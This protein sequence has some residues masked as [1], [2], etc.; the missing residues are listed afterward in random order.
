M[1]PTPP[2]IPNPKETKK[3]KLF[4]V[5]GKKLSKGKVE[6]TIEKKERKKLILPSY[7][8]SSFLSSLS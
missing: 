7:P 5:A 1:C 4:A 6:E 2:P 3:K 8:V